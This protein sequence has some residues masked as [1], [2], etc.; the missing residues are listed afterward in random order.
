MP[1]HRCFLAWFGTCA[2]HPSDVAPL[3]VHRPYGWLT[4]E[5][6]DGSLALARRYAIRVIVRI[7]TL[8]QGPCCMRLMHPASGLLSAVSRSQSPLLCTDRGR[9]AGRE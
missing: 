6:D 3:D 5:L 4:M 7:S 8:V 9:P 2:T 1:G